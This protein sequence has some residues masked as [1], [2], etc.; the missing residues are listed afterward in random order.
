[1]RFAEELFLFLLDEP[2]GALL[3]VAERTLH[4]AFAGAVLMDLERTG[5]IDTD[6]DTLMLA[7]T[8][9]VDDDLLD[10]TLADIVAAD[11]SHDPIFWVERAADRGVQIRERTMERLV[12]RGVLLAPEA[13]GFLALSQAVARTR[14]YPAAGDDP[15]GGDDAGREDIRLR[16]MRVL[17]DDDIPHPAEIAVISLAEACDVF[18]YVM[19]AS[20]LA[21]AR[22][23]IALLS[24]MDL[25]GQAV[26]KLARVV[27]P[28]RRADSDA[29]HP[30]PPAARGRPLVGNALAMM[31]D[32]T[33]FF[34]AQHRKLGSVFR[35]RIFSNT[36]TVLAGREANLFMQRRERFHLGAG[37]MWKAFSKELGA[38]RFLLGMDGAEHLR[39]RRAMKDGF[40][41]A[42]FNDRIADLVEIVRRQIAEWPL[43]DPLPGFPT[44]QRIATE[45]VGMASGGYSAREYV[46]DLAF[47][48]KKL[49]ATRVLR[50]YPAPLYTPRFKRALRRVEELCDQVLAS[51]QLEYRERPNDLIDDLIT[52]HRADPMFLP[53]TDLTIGALLPFIVGIDTSASTMSFMLY[54]LLKHPDL[55]ERV[56]AE[57]EALFAGDGPTAEKIRGLDVTR[58]V[59]METLR[60]YPVTAGLRRTVATSFD[61]EGYRLKAGQPVVVAT[62]V[63][64]Y[65]PEYFPAPE[66]FDID[67]Y[68]P[69]RAEHQQPGVYVPFGV[70]AHRCLGADFAQGQIALTLATLAHDTRIALDPPNYE[71]RTFPQPFNSPRKQFRF[72]L[73]ERR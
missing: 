68:L 13:D 8:T 47:F 66:R 61:F 59:A 14:R 69:E 40:S 39:L 31:S 56:R 37:D 42:R 28:L 22:D 26:A 73:L 9:P 35:I 53:E 38:S 1:M 55:W 27:R 48:F 58:R 67:R 44:M 18:R 45:Q 43:N 54:A 51:H 70:G 7:D 21:A 3:P 41:R 50:R 36:H 49:V 11:E 32:A 23:R 64:H 20:E 52:L 25:V 62:A 5:R 16:L 4:L 6:L 60:M 17:F 15:A 29:Q 72:R 2:N 10:P 71:M 34:T 65:L 46:D 19:T 57:A 24:R 63:T 33:G 30:D 12:E